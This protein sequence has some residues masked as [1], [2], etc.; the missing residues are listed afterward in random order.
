MLERAIPFSASVSRTCA[1]PDFDRSLLFCE[2][3]S[4][5]PNTFQ[6]ADH[7]RSTGKL[8]GAFWTRRT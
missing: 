3:V 6:K 2:D 1:V 7:Y 8:Y 5:G 4:G